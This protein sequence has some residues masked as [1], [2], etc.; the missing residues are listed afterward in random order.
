[1]SWKKRVEN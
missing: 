1:M